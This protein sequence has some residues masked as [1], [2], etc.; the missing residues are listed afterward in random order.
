MQ[1]AEMIAVAGAE[2]EFVT[3]ER[4]LSPEI[5]A[6]NLTPYI[7]ALQPLGV[8]FT[9]CRRL[10]SVEQNEGQL[11]AVCGSDYDDTIT[12]HQVDQVV[13]ENATQPHEDLY[14]DLKPLSSNLGEVDY[15]ALLNGGT[16]SRQ[17]N[18]DGGF[19]LFRIGDA[20]SSRNVH[21]AILDALRLLKDL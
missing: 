10:V 5:G 18:P 21:A 9:L 7:R 16:Q 3:P 1:A 19:Q 15:D 14:F 8:T 11:T 6:L 17:A 20:V 4:T 2:L 13:V 12:R